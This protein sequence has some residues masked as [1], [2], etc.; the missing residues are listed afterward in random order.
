AGRSAYRE[1][2]TCFESQVHGQLAALAPFGQRLER[3]QRLL[4]TRDRLALGAGPRRLGPRGAVELGRLLPQPTLQRMVGE[5]L[6]LL[7]QA[8]RR[9]LL[10]HGDEL[11]MERSALL[12]EER[13]VGDL[14]SEGML[15]GVLEIGE[16]ARLVEELRR[17]QP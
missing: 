17:L 15:E 11:G 4:E 2:I 14:V 3:A 16:E 1:A 7:G 9:H 10:D 6:D 13:A 8:P 12:V 5:A